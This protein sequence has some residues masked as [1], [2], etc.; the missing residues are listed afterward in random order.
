MG[1][2]DQK[3][4]VIVTR[5]VPLVKWIRDNNVIVDFTM[6]KEVQKESLERGTFV[7]VLIVV[8]DNFLPI[9]FSIL[10]DRQIE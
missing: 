1:I 10:A 8:V 7:Y 2:E 5:K 4:K 9:P 3:R 6:L